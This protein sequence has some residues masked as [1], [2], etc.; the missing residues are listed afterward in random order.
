ML[1]N[2]VA[3]T[4]LVD[5]SVDR[6]I[7]PLRIGRPGGFLV[8][9]LA[10]PLDRSGQLTLHSNSPTAPGTIMRL[11]DALEADYKELFITHAPQSGHTL[12]LLGMDACAK[13]WPGNPGRAPK[14]TFRATPANPAAGAEFDDNGVSLFAGNNWKLRVFKIRLV[15]SATAANRRIM[16]VITSNTQI[17]HRIV[18]PA[19]QT[20]GLTVDYFLAV[21]QQLS[22]DITTSPGNQQIP[23]HDMIL[24]D[25]VRLQTVTAAIQVGDQFSAAVFYAEQW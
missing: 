24:V 21:G 25:A 17:A 2:P 16:F 11:G 19:I 8:V 20:A 22:Y 6:T 4:Q 9:S 14:G 5:L 15:T 3:W 18:A 23:M 1:R 7:L 12:T 13:F 10:S